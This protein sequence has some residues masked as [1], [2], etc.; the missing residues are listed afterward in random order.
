M[1]DYK[2]W[3]HRAILFIEELQ[4][5]KPFFD[6]IDIVSSF[7]SPLT[8][9]EI[10]EIK[11]KSEKYIPLELIN[12]WTTGSANLSCHYYLSKPK[13]ERLSQINEMFGLQNCIYGGASFMI[14]NK[15]PEKLLDLKEWAE[16]TW[17]VEYPNEQK[18][19]L[20]SVPFFEMRN[21]DYLALDI[22]EEKDNP[23]VIYLSHDDE[24]S[25]ISE[26]FTDF[27]T[28]WESLCYIGPEGWLLDIFQNEKGFIC[29]DSG[30][31]EKL[32]N[33]FAFQD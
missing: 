11:S 6:E 1:F 15:L 32:R 20:N 19:W 5:L 30:K 26:S 8:E 2:N 33:I 28:N 7:Q 10:V 22:A 12:F 24:S 31:A 27:L 23:P 3:V 21:G 9:A 25:V 16:E 4:K 14:A 18:F 13:T 17:I 29:P